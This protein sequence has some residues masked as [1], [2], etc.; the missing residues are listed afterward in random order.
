MPLVTFMQIT[1]EKFLEILSQVSQ[2]D[3]L[4]DWQITKNISFSIEKTSKDYFIGINTAFDNDFCEIY[5]IISKDNYY[6]GK[7]G[8]QKINISI[9]DFLESSDVLFK[10]DIEKLRKILYPI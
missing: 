6:I 2:F 9:S 3:E 10:I 8:V 7:S 1:Q 5:I 4:V